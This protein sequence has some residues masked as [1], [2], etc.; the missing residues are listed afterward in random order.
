VRKPKTFFVGGSSVDLGLVLVVVGR[1]GGASSMLRVGTRSPS[2]DE[3]YRVVLVPA[4][5]AEVDG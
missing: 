3:S 2:V 4:L 5:A 1:A